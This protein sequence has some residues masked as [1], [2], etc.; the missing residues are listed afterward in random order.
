MVAKHWREFFANFDARYERW[1]AAHKTGDPAA[2]KAAEN[3]LPGLT[4]RARADLAPLD[5]EESEPLLNAVRRRAIVLG[6][7]RG[8][9]ERRRRREQRATQKRR[10]ERTIRVSRNVELPTAC[11]RC[12]TKLENPKTTGRPRIYCSPACRKAAYDDR[13]SRSDGA[14]K[15]QVVE[16]VVTEVRERRVDVTHPRKTCI[17][18]VFDDEAA[19]VDAIRALTARIR[20][21]DDRLLRPTRSAFWDLCN[22]IEVLHEALIE[23]ATY[24]TPPMSPDPPNRHQHNMQRFTHKSSRE[25]AEE[26]PDLGSPSAP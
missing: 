21:F 7:E 14:A 26:E 25:G 17:Q 5:H 15:V 4:E 6:Y 22:D 8:A 18:A 23:R 11:A 10:E 24:W 12:E 19:I 9:Y 1:I 16:R 2:I 13:R 3:A 20:D